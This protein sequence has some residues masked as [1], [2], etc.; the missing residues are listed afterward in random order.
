MSD[1]LS[2]A[3]IR[4]LDIQS[5][6]NP[7]Q[8]IEQIKV[9][10]TQDF[11][12]DSQRALRYYEAKSLFTM[13]QFDKVVQITIECLGESIKDKDYFILVRCN[14][15]QGLC[16]HNMNDELRNRPC[17]EMALEYAIQADDFELLIYASCYYLTFLRK[18][19][20][21]DLA[22]EEEK[23]ILDLVKRI[24]AT[25]TSIIALMQVSSL[26]IDLHKI[27]KAIK[28]LLTAYEYSQALNIIHIKLTIINNLATLYSKIED[29]TKAKMLLENGLNAAIE[30]QNPQQQA[31]MQFNL[32]N[33]MI[34]MDNYHAALDYFDN[35]IS[36]AQECKFISPLFLIDI[37]N[38]YSMCYSRLDDLV[39]SIEYIDKAIT[40]AEENKLENDKIQMEESKA[41]ILYQMGNFEAT[42]TI[43][44]NAIKFFKKTN[45]YP[46]LL[47]ANISLAKFYA[48]NKD[49]KGSVKVYE[50]LSNIFDEYVTQ[51]MNKQIESETG[52][53]NVKELFASTPTFNPT[54]TIAN[55]M[56]G[57]VGKSKASQDVLNAAL[58]AAQH[59]NTNVMIVGESGTGKEVIARIIHNNS[60]RRNYNF[61][62]VNVSSLSANLIESE[63]FGHTRGAFTGAQEQTKGFFLQADKG[64][65][66]LDEITELPY[67]LQSKLLRVIETQ[68]VVSVGSSIETGYDSRIICATNQSPREQISLN[69]FRL[70]LYHRLN[71]IE[72][73]IPPLRERPEDIEP[74]LMH[75]VDK[76]ATELKKPKPFIDKSLISLM[77][78]YAYPGNVRELKNMVERMYILSS[79]LQWD[80]TLLCRI[81]PYI[82]APSEVE[83]IQ[84]KEEE[85]ILKAL[86]K[87]KGKQKDAAIALGIS[88]ATIHRRIAKYNLQQYTSK[89]N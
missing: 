43:L 8:T 7:Q 55:T 52:K 20:A 67:E 41:N 80:A 31:L 68:K 72:I 45:Q 49:F 9:L 39:K 78:Q 51:I 58:L 18:I 44:K 87:A 14:V 86:I 77:Q 3:A 48:Q 64:S 65:I 63:L 25:Y 69:K 54:G 10:L 26:Y 21:F 22:L 19:P 24:P 36:A 17:L 12:P 1:M 89:G 6:I 76:Y 73:V 71:T 70:D 57:F 4:N 66:F 37:Y 34:A 40:I 28:V 30:I 53:L 16:Y 83:E 88:E 75:Y 5:E 60:L 38:N 74:I 32:G 81:N 42:K 13:R 84:L 15:L 27:D 59:Q 46:H 85:L 61:V 62:S 33:L 11:S 47:R 35:S 56:Q 50:R 23:R 82:E 2:M 79:S 29:Y